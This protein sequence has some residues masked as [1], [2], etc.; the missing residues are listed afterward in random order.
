MGA[1]TASLLLVVLTARTPALFVRAAAQNEDPSLVSQTQSEADTK[2]VG[3]ISCHSQTDEPTM[4][5][6][7][8]VRLGCTDCHGGNA[9]VRIGAGVTAKSTEYD[10]VKLQA[11]PQPRDRELQNRSANP[12]RAYTQWLKESPEYVRFVNPGDLRVAA[13]TCGTSGCHT[14]EVRNVSTSM[15]TTGGM[16]WGAALY[17][18]GGYPHKDTQFGESYAHDGT[19]QAIRTIPPPTP[20][21]TRKKGVLPEITP[22]ERWEISQPGNV[23]RVFERGG[24]P[25]GEV[26]EPLRADNAGKPDD[27][28]STR[29]L[30]T[31][32]RTDPV[33]LGL[34][35]TRL[36]DPLLSLPGTN[37]QP[38]DYRASGCTACHVIYANDR[39][40][41][42]SAQYAPFG[43][44]GFSA[45]NDPTIPH[46]ESGH[47]IRHEFTRSIPSS[48]CMVCHI[49]PGTNLVATY[50]GYTWWDNES[51]GDA[52][53]P[54]QQRNPTEEEKFRVSQRN[55]EGAAERGLWSD[56]KFLAETGTAQFNQK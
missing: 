56:M 40:A 9:D 25:K 41:E 11:H 34:Q 21:E 53:Y 44:R 48:Q 33:F 39:S 10:Q 31:E 51:D 42:H 52:M 23:L 43:N 55:P 37:D 27:K 29:G 14:S 45:S 2:S 49:H 8:T 19:P 13:E 28:L 36:L 7:G 32:L 12:E 16:L 38:G 3:C 6:T 15:M 26:G 18:N 30:G 20:E 35:K 4:H 50:F 1:L 5:A 47:P 22:L 24:G 17:N 46:E 54:K